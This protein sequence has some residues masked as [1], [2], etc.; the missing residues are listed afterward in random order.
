MNFVAT[1]DGARETSLPSLR[2]ANASIPRFQN[3]FRGWKVKPKR[4]QR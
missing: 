4:L 1:A 2:L 3:R